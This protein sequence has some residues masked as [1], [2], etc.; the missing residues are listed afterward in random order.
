MKSLI[1]LLS[2]SLT[3]FALPLSITAQVAQ[4]QEATVKTSPMPAE[5]AKATFEDARVKTFMSVV[6][7]NFGGKCSIPDHTKTEARLTQ[8][9]SG[10]FSSSF[11]EVNLPCPGD[12][13]LTGVQITVEFSP[14]LGRPL[15]LLLSLQYRQ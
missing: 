13:G 1:L 5:R 8:I 12:N 4:A 10:D 14:P 6:A 9:G 3:L 15:N 7:K 11:Y 2:I